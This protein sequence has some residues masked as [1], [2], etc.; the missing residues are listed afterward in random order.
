MF[1]YCDLRYPVILHRKKLHD[2]NRDDLS[3][4]LLIHSCSLHLFYFDALVQLPFFVLLKKE[5]PDYQTM[6]FS[7]QVRGG[8]GE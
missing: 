2:F 6:K 8:K 5:K 3:I 7:Y 1:A 4:R